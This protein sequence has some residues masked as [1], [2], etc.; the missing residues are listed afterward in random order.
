MDRCEAEPDLAF[1][2]NSKAVGHLANAAKKAETYFVQ[3]S[4]D[5]VF[6]GEKGNYSETDPPHPI[7]SYGLSKLEG[8]RASKAPGEGKWCVAR[9]SVVYGWGRPHRPNAATFVYEKLSKGE[10]VSM[11]WD[12]YS[13][14]TINTNLATM[15]LEIVERRVSGIIHTAGASRLSRYDFALGLAETLGLN[16]QLISA[17]DAGNMHWKARR[18]R[19]SSLNVGRANRELTQKPLEI[20]KAYEKFRQESVEAKSAQPL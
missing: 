1:L 11:V 19:D 2:V 14:P 16:K 17:V 10:P 15:I 8:E 18:P 3:L 7:N 4:T 20:R 12:Q 5:Y 9:A 13:S 6:D